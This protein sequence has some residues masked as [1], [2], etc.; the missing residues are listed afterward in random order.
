M[1]ESNVLEKQKGFKKG[2][3]YMNQLFTVRQLSEKV[4][5]KNKKM[6]VHVLIWKRPIQQRGKR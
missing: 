1:T 3:S 4:I 2:R 6:V 5:I